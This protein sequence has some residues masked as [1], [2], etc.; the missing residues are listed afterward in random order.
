MIIRQ[1]RI[2]VITNIGIPQ[3]FSFRDSVF[4]LSFFCPWQCIILTA[5]SSIAP[6][7]EVV[8]EATVLAALEDEGPN[9][10]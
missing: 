8:S 4:L 3:S 6:S 9:V 5:P 7:Q 1:T 10:L 2:I